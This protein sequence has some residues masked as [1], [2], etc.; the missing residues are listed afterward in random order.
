MAHVTI[1]GACTRGLS[2]AFDRHGRPAPLGGVGSPA[3]RERERMSASR[4]SASTSM[5]CKY[6]GKAAGRAG[7]AGPGRVGPGRAGPS[8]V[9][10]GRVAV[11]SGWTH[12]G[13]VGDGGGASAAAL[14]GGDAFR[15]LTRSVAHGRVAVT[16]RRQCPVAGR[17]AYQFCPF[18]LF[19]KSFKNSRI[20]KKVVCNCTPET[21]L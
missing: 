21:I 9:G 20:P 10:T 4:V 3:A 16:A 14:D 17:A 5:K 18:L 15:E 13:W 6:V 11:G 8:R 1:T 7:R 12:G 19:K 2:G